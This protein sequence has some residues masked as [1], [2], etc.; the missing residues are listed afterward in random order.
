MKKLHK[1]DKFDIDNNPIGYA[2]QVEMNNLKRDLNK[3]VKVI[4]ILIEDSNK[5]Q[6]NCK[7]L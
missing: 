1:L 5:Q 6:E 2:T 4:N 3:M 7:K